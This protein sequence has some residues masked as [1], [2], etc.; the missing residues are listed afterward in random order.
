MKQYK[1]MGPDGNFYFSE[2]KGQ[3]GGYSGKIKIY[4]SLDCPS[5]LNWIAK[6]FYVDKRVFFKDEKN[7]ILAGFR[8]CAFCQREK[9]LKW[10]ENPENFKNEILNSSC[11]EMEM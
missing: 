2:S 5:A 7:A 3:L 1:L 9:Y 4:G 6:G 10:K 11:E 8:P